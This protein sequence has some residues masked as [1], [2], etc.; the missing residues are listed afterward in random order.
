MVYLL[1]EILRCSIP[2][3]GFPFGRIGYGVSWSPLVYYAMEGGPLLVSIMGLLCS[4][5]LVAGRKILLALVFVGGGCLFLVNNGTA[6]E[7]SK[8]LVAA[9]QGNMEQI[10]LG[11]SVNAAQI[12]QNQVQATR[13]LLNQSTEPVQLI[14]W[15]ENSLEDDLWNPK[16]AQIVNQ[17]AELSREYSAPIL[18]GSQRYTAEG[19]YNRY[20]LITKDGLNDIYYDK[21]SPVPFGEYI[22]FR[23]FFRL[24]SLKV[25]LIPIDMLAGERA[26]VLDIPLD[27]GQSLRVGVLICFE[28]TQDYL[29]DAINTA[30]VDLIIAPTNN[31]FFGYTSEAFQQFSIARLRAIQT[32]QHLLQVATTG[33]SGEVWPNGQVSQQIGLYVSGGFVSVIGID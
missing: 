5:L 1:T 19:R 22:P 8:V 4:I 31:V 27:N 15:P 23:D 14:V 6:T 7:Q 17:L 20:A 2:F 11:E 13:E 10:S 18:V 26:N 21:L 3:G 16:K 12:F 25:D 28:I 32:H 30:D 33:I 9:V 29:V 24:I